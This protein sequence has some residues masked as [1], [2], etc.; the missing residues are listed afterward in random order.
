MKKFLLLVC[1]ITLT[2]CATGERVARHL[3]PGADK[4]HVLQVMGKP[5]GYKQYNGLEVY[6]YSNRL[7]S[8]WSWDTTDYYLVFKNDKLKEYSHSPVRVHKPGHVIINTL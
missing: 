3:Y 1:V 8:G 2:A 5:D 6:I 4:G 7:I